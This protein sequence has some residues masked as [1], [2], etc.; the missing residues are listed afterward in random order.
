MVSL[1]SG[2]GR[3]VL[4]PSVYKALTKLNRALEHVDEFERRVADL[5]TNARVSFRFDLEALRVEAR[6]YAPEF[7]DHSHRLSSVVGDAVHNLRASLNYLVTALVAANGVELQRRHAFPIYLGK[8]AF[9]KKVGSAAAPA[10]ELAGIRLGF[11][12]IERHQPF[13]RGAP[14]PSLN[15]I[16]YLA[17]LQRLSNADKHLSALQV[18]PIYWPTGR[19]NFGSA[20]V[21]ET[22]FRYQDQSAWLYEDDSRWVEFSLD[23]APDVLEFAGTFSVTTLVRA[24]P[25]DGEPDSHW[26]GTVLRS[27]WEKV[28]QVV[29][30]VA[31][32]LEGSD[33]ARDQWVRTRS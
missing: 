19:F 30:D 32:L 21:L 15:G 33:G 29:S 26:D 1:D 20:R 2:D 24:I 22:R 7:S 23:R 13:Q 5:E 16:H 28:G 8:E 17:V 31:E 6:M 4:E 27:V 11:D 18:L 12:V 10:G 14:D 9:E 25:R 3:Y